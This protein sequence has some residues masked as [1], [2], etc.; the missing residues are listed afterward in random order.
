MQSRYG[1]GRKDDYPPVRCFE[2]PIPTGPQKGAVL[3][4]KKYDAMLSKYYKHR[5]WSDEGVPTEKTLK[6]L[7]LQDVADDL[8][9]RKVIKANK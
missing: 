4:K 5:G 2:E 3:D 9:K 6:E 8:K 7:G 1:L